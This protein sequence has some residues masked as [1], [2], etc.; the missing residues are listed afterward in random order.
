MPAYSAMVSRAF[1]ARSSAGCV[2]QT[3]DA[4]AGGAGIAGL[5]NNVMAPP[6]RFMGF[7]VVLLNNKVLLG[8]DCALTRHACFAD[9][10]CAQSCWRRALLSGRHQE[11]EFVRTPF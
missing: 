2:G 4:C 9:G 7:F 5:K 3:S 6:M 8:T 1:I 10:S 11:G